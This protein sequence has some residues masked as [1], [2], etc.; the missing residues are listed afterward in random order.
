MRADYF[1]QVE[2]TNLESFSGGFKV[3]E[4]VPSLDTPVCT[5]QTKQLEFAA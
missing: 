1:D 3:I 2:T 5:M 4:T